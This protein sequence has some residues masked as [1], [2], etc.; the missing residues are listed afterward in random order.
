MKVV[1]IVTE[2]NPFH[3]GHKYIISRAK[4]LTGADYCIVIMSGS[5]TQRGTPS[6]MY[7]YTRTSAALACGADLVLELPVSYAT[8]TAETFCFGAI[9]VL[10]AL[11]VVDYVAFGSESGDLDTLMSLSNN[12]SDIPA[13]KQNIIN[14]YLEQGYSYPAAR[15]KAFPEYSDILNSPNNI[16]AIEYLKALDKLNST[17][18]PITIA[19][20]GNN[21]H[22]TTLGEYASAEGIREAIQSIPNNKYINQEF[23]TKEQ[24]ISS[25]QG[26]PDD[27]SSL[28]AESLGIN[29]P[30]EIDDYNDL[31]R[32]LLLSSSAEAL[33]EYQDMNIDIARRFKN[34]ELSFKSISSYILKLKT[35]ELT[36]SRL[37]RGI[38]H[39]LLGI[40][41]LT[42]TTENELIACPYS[43][44]LG[45]NINS[46]E[47]MHE[48]SKLS[49]IPLINKAADARSI[50]DEHQYPY[51]E[52]TLKSDRIW[53]MIVAK[54]YGTHLKDGCL[55]SPII[56]S[57]EH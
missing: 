19:R 44:I 51:Y 1:G 8:A 23:S 26:I 24:L 37:S 34:D 43:R 29:W 31:F 27:I 22:D 52:L 46:R 57:C 25:I 38:L 39:C 53:D 21:Y 10:N 41:D 15:A 35:K 4:A 13:D 50:L 36:H 7:K 14:T 2:F 33:S 5:F 48:I 30:I 40:K 17:I 16:L 54:K 11:Q 55:I 45:F 18:I 42:R 12:L 32:Y 6:C 47:L 49:L 56:V 3:N 20:K 28:Y 9:S